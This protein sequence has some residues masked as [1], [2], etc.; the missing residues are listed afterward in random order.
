MKLSQ[1]T[2]LATRCAASALK[3][4]PWRQAAGLATLALI[5]GG[6]VSTAQAKLLVYE[7]F[8]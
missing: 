6:I 1:L 4:A 3:A 8:D 2:S 7:P 5:L